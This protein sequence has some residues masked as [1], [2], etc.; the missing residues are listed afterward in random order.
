MFLPLFKE[1]VFRK[2]IIIDKE[3]NKT[4]LLYGSVLFE[5]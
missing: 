5:Y 2:D 1:Y 3:F 4:F